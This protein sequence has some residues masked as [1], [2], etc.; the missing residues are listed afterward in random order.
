MIQL[1]IDQNV[2]L[3]VSLDQQI[4]L[5][6]ENPFFSVG[7]IPVPYSLDVE[8]PN[9][10]HNVKAIKSLTK[11]SVFE[12]FFDNYMIFK[13]SISS[14]GQNNELIT[15]NLLGANLPISLSED[16]CKFDLGKDTVNLGA[17]VE[18]ARRKKQINSKA[19]I[20]YVPHYKSSDSEMVEDSTDLSWVYSKYLNW[21]DCV[22]KTFFTQ[23]ATGAIMNGLTSP[24]IKLSSL[25]K[26]ILPNSSGFFDNIDLYVAAHTASLINFESSSS[27]T[28]DVIFN[29]FF[30]EI[31]AEDFVASV[32]NLFCVT[33]YAS[34]DGF[35]FKS[36]K[37]ILEDYPYYDWSN[38]VDNEYS[39]TIEPPQ[40]YAAYFSNGYFNSP[41]NTGMLV[42]PSLQSLVDRGVVPSGSMWELSHYI[43]GND[44]YAWSKES[45]SYVGA[46]KKSK[47]DEDTDISA[48]VDLAPASVYVGANAG[49]VKNESINEWYSWLIPNYFSAY[50]DDAPI[51]GYLSKGY[52]YYGN[53]NGL[54]HYLTTYNKDMAGDDI[55]DDVIDLQKDSPFYDKWHKPFE[56][57]LG[58]DQDVISIKVAVSAKELANLDL[59]KTVYYANYEY[60]IKTFDITVFYNHL[61]YADVKLMKKNN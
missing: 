12:V 47:G 14:R 42:L 54:Y 7:E 31:S 23:S 28:E 19:D 51:I 36:R 50:I 5:V 21:Y 56:K 58:N 18:N 13:G 17:T 10:P 35:V 30:E 2:H 43:V 57:L 9:T 29:E 25:V 46:I 45:L 6:F 61:A 40:T 22:R 32:M 8:I 24:T 48:S 26:H 3:D 15:F 37:Q 11:E 49:L 59:S 53:E 16:L 1:I 38:K 60:L 52:L 20:I 44:V 27:Q 4:N 34:G 55:A 39:L 41:M 33:C